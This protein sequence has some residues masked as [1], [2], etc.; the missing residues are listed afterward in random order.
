MVRPGAWKQ[1]LPG[2]HFYILLPEHKVHQIADKSMLPINSGI[3]LFMSK[4][5]ACNAGTWLPESG[6]RE[7]PASL[8]SH[9]PE[10]CLAV[11][12]REKR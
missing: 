2:S 9:T 11:M 3:P 12:L 10:I 7:S 6:G 4:V 5:K 1:G 8:H